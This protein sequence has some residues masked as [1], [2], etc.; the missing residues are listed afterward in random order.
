M[1]E[2]VSAK[3]HNGTVTVIYTE[4]TWEWW[5]PSSWIID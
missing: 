2:F 4:L 1:C 5:Y 3:E